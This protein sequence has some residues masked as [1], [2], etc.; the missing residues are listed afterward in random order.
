MILDNSGLLFHTVAIN[1]VLLLYNNEIS[2]QICIDFSAENG[3]KLP[4][5]AAK[6]CCNTL[7]A[8][9]ECKIGL[10]HKTNSPPLQIDLSRLFIQSGSEIWYPFVKS[11]N[12]ETLHIRFL[13]KKLHSPTNHYNI[14]IWWS[15]RFPLHMHFKSCY[16]KYW[17]NI[18]N[19]SDRIIVN[20]VYNMGF[21][22]PNWV[23]SL[24]DILKSCNLPKLEHQNSFSKIEI[25]NALKNC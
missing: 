9:T 14:N 4:V 6:A 21:P 11:E 2:N 25:Q 20:K 8:I 22:K 15:W 13:K 19:Q 17:F 16:I 18:V 1:N 5:A 3:R 24:F 23:C 10:N 7:S 12:L